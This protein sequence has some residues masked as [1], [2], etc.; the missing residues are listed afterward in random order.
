MSARPARLLSGR[1]QRA[2]AFELPFW[3]LAIFTFF[4]V[5]A[6]WS[7]IFTEI[8]IYVALLGLVLRPADLRF[9]PP[10][11]WATA[12]L[13]W[14]VV[15]ALF[16][17]SQEAAW[18]VL[19]ERLKALVVFFVVI[20]VIRT[21]RQLRFFI[22]LILFAFLIYPARGTLKNYMIGETRF[23]R[24][25][26]NKIYSNA[27]DLAGITLLM[28][29][30]TL[31]I[32][33]VKAQN[34]RIRQAVTFL[35]PLLL[36][37]VLLTQSRGVFIGLLVGFGPPLLARWRKLPRMAAPVLILV[38]VVVLF[39]VPHAAWQ[40]LEGI[41][42]L[43]STAGIAQSDSSA[44][45]RFEILKTGLHIVATHPVLGVGI[46]CYPVANELY[47]PELGERDAHNTYV[48]LA[49]EMGI[50][51]ML[52]WL[53]LVGSVL[54]HVR[55][56]RAAVEADEQPIGILWIERAIIAYLVAGFFGTYSGLTIFYLALGTLWVGSS[57]LG[58]DPAPASGM[59]IGR[60]RLK[61]RQY[62]R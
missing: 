24:V 61:P 38:C 5:T 60:R 44:R 25:A 50:P 19:I 16:A 37:I 32:A 53:A 56:R 48:G 22:F 29:G 57:M 59:A 42:K 2:P 26:W 12:F 4:M 8:G 39:V 11:R 18:P 41:T 43:T 14:A 15:T 13:L 54:R 58:E 20:N 40:R 62:V 21:P 31:A 7:E 9:P 51:G 36:L 10:L 52:L 27:N 1:L 3:G 28:L 17:M 23:G 45:Q 30:W 33:T 35:V 6:R 47:A 34:A 46:G 55:R 49:A